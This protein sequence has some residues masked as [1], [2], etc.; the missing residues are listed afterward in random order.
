MVHIHKISISICACKVDSIILNWD[1]KTRFEKQTVSNSY[2]KWECPI[3]LL[4]RSI[5]E[6]TK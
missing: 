4:T 5:L 2:L 6:I 3:L 1:I